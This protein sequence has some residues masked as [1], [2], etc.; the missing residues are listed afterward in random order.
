MVLERGGM[1]KR[2]YQ[3]G[4]PCQGGTSVGPCMGTRAADGSGRNYSL[5]GSV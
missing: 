4:L 2:R 5:P 3:A 1:R